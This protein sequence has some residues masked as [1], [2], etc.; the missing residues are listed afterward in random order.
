METKICCDSF[1]SF[2]GH[3]FHW[4]SYSE[5]DGTKVFVM[6]FLD[7]NGQKFRVNNCPSCGTE[8]RS[9][10]LSEKEFYDLYL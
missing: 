8:V 6:P 10:R 1:R 3:S 7:V 5:D 4:M 2:A 9:I